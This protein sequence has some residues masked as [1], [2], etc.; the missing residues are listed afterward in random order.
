VTTPTA[1]S[2]SSS[3]ETASSSGDVT[4]LDLAGEVCPYTF[5]RTRLALEDLPLGAR[6]DVLVDHEPARRNVPRSAIE[7][8]QEVLAVDEVTPGRWRIAL[9]KRAC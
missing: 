9:C 2:T 7:W 6:L 8:G 3:P 1:S 4:T 5:V